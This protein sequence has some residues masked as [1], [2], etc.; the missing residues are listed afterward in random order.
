ME[1]GREVLKSKLPAVITVVKEIG[2]PRLATVRNKMKAKKEEIQVWGPEEIGATSRVDRIE[3]I[4]HSCGQDCHHTQTNSKGR[5]SK[6]LRS[7]SIE[8]CL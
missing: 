4:A 5:N 3:R 2:V 7:E 6:D 8:K 1:G